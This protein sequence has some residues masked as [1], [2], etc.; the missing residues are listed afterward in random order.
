M[1]SSCISDS[2]YTVFNNI[3]IRATG[4]LAKWYKKPS[5][6]TWTELDH[7]LRVHFYGDNIQVRALYNKQGNVEFIIRYYMEKNLPLYIRNLI[8]SA[9]C[10]FSV[11]CVTEVN[12]ENKR[13]YYVKIEDET[14]WKTIRITGREMRVFDVCLKNRS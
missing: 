4:D 12:I 2:T 5:H 14:C 7:D 1:Q 8:K 11:F 3:N 9:Y 13:F 6:I 10:D